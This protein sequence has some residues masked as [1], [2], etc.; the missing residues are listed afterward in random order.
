[1]ASWLWGIAQQ[2]FETFGVQ[3]LDDS[4]PREEGGSSRL[5]FLL[6][7]TH[8]HDDGWVKVDKKENEI[9]NLSWRTT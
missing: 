9:H 3:R 8:T 7:G 6:K 5:P 1:M 4:E 2:T